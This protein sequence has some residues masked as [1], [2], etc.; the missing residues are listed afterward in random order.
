MVGS[1]VAELISV[2]SGEH[3]VVQAPLGH[4]LAHLARLPGVQ[5]RRRSGG[6]NR[7]EAT[8]ARARVSHDH[9]GGRGDAILAASPALA[10]VRA[11]RLFTHRGQA[12]TS[13]GVS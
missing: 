11:P 3:H 1:L 9:D 5:R 10:D 4:R 6:L 13:H 2:D 7:A 12:Q 8:T